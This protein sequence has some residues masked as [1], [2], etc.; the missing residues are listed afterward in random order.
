MCVRRSARPN[1]DDS[2]A[3]SSLPTVPSA[4]PARS[5]TCSTACAKGVGSCLLALGA[6]QSL[7]EFIVGDD[8]VLV[9]VKACGDLLLLV[10]GSAKPRKQRLEI[11]LGHRTCCTA[12]GQC[13]CGLAH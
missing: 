12:I 13:R 6:R 4:L 2:A 8:T 11:V 9:G 3:N 7:E 1:A 10:F 5:I